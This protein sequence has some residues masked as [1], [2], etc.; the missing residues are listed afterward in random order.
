MRPESRPTTTFPLVLTALT[1]SALSMAVDAVPKYSQDAFVFGTLL[2]V[3]FA[4]VV[5]NRANAMA[6]SRFRSVAT[7]LLPTVFG[8]AIGMGVQAIVLADVG[9]SGTEAVRDLGGLVDTLSPTTWI[10]SGVLLGG[11]PALLVALFLT[12][13]SRALRR[14]GGHDAFESFN[15]GFT[16]LAGIAAGFGVVL[17][18]GI[19]VAPL[20]LVLF[21]SAL[22]ILIAFVADGSRLRFIRRVYAGEERSFQIVDAESFAQDVSLASLVGN[23]DRS[24]VL[25][26]TDAF[27]S[28]RGSA[29]EPVALVASTESATVRPLLRRRVAAGA[30]LGGMFTLLGLAAM[31]HDVATAWR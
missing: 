30:L 27:G 29:S 26:R 8:A 6:G 19:A 18:D 23:G 17:V 5:A 7:L 11:A 13:A 15:V 28:Y 3:V 25:V 22:T 4:L 31:A 14:L 2:T 16:G 9:S 10:A 12:L 20:F 1:V 24:S 21:A